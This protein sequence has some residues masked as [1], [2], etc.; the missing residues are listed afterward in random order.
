MSTEERRA[1]IRRIVDG[2]PALTTEDA[3]Q[4]RALLPLQA[5]TAGQRTAGGE[6]QRSGQRTA[7]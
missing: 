6:R 3:D 1:Y 2:A 5:R 4:L 7:A